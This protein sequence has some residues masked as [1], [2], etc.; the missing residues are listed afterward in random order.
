MTKQTAIP[1]F[2][3]A[4]RLESLSP[5]IR[6]AKTAIGADG[7]RARLRTR[8]LT[9]GPD[10]V[11]EH[12]LIEMVLFLAL[13]RR[14][15]K[16]IARALLSRFGSYAA[17][18][19]ASVP[20]LLAVEGLGEAGAAALKIVQASAQRL[21]KAEVLYRPVLSN[22]DRLME[23]LQAVLAREKTEQFRVLFLDNRNRLLGDE[24]QSTGTVN[25]TPVY[26]REVVKRALELHATAIILVHN[27]PS[28]D[29]SPSEEDI[30]MTKQIKQAA[31]ALSIVLHDHIIIGN[32]QWVSF[33]KMGLM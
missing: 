17:A 10:A 25:H 29:P 33:R 2:A 1:G 14:D 12:E 22:W 16:P 28:G 31:I 5:E 13:P 6:P 32:G 30:M 21:A 7:H 24:V 19:S 11:A 23:Y 15:T 27:H 20:D 18:I 8:F 9:A 4:T 26:P 3:D